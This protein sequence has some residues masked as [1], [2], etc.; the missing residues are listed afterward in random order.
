MNLPLKRVLILHG[1]GAN[2]KS[3]W[4]P[5][6]KKTLEERYVV[7]CPD[8]PNS[9]TPK[10]SEWLEAAKIARPF[11]ETLS[12][13]GHSLGS[14]LLLRLLEE[15]GEKEKIDKAIIVSGFARDIGIPLIKGFVARPF[16]WEKIRKKARRFFVLH[17]DNDPVVPLELGKEVAQKLNAE[18]IIEKNGGHLNL[19]IDENGRQSFSYYRLARIISGEDG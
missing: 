2:S 9:F 7:Y 16:K 3:N 4:F 1:W 14:V 13:V 10:L 18:M 17:S 8:L 19:G 5:W 6:L 15:L 12:I 11:D